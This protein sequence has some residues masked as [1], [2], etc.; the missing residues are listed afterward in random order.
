M[1]MV[2]FW[3]YFQKETYSNGD[4]SVAIFSDA[5]TGKTFKVCGNGVPTAK[6]IKYHLLGE[7]TVYKKTGEESLKLV[8]YEIAELDNE[9]SF[10]EYLAMPPIKLSRVQGKKIY[11][12]FREQAV[13]TLDHEPEKVYNAVFKGLKNGDERYKRFI[14]EWKRQRKLLKISS[15]LVKYG[16]SRKNVMKLNDAVPMSKY[17]DLG[18]VIRDNPYFMM[19]VPGVHIDIGVCDEIA[20]RLHYPLNSPERIKAGMKYVL[21]TAMMNGNMFLYCFGKGGLIEE[22]AKKINVR[23]EEIAAVLNTKPQGFVIESDKTIKNYRI[24]LDYAHEWEVGLAR[25]VHRFLTKRVAKVMDAKGVEKFL[26][27][28]QQKKSITLAEKQKEAVYAVA[29]SPITIITGGAG[30]GKTTSLKAVLAMLDAAGKDNN[31]LL[32]STGKASQRMTETTGRMATTIHSCIACDDSSEDGAAF[33]KDIECDAL[34]IDEFSMT[35]CKVAYL[36]FSAVKSCKR[37]IIVGDVEQLPSVGAGNVLKDMINSGRVRVVALDVIQR[38]AL[39]SPI[40]ANAQKVLC[41]ESDFVFNENFRFI[42]TKDGEEAAEYIVKRYIELVK[43]HGMGAV[44]I[45][46]PMKKRVCGTVM[47]NEAIQNQLFPSLKN[48]K[49][50]IGDKV[51]NTKNNHDIGL[52]NGDMG[53]VTSIVDEEY[54]I[55]F[56][57][58]L[59]LTFDKMEMDH[60]VLAYSVTVHK[61]QGS[62]FPYVIMPI[63]NEHSIMLYRNLL[64]TGITRAKVNIE[65]VGTE[66]MLKKAAETVKIVQ[67]NTML[68]KRL[69]FA[70]AVFDKKKVS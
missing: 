47:L 18:A 55:E 58:G 51:M 21:R 15:F 16:I 13:E 32:A 67:R 56:D 28:Y 69:Q 42:K 65:L 12:L 17:D 31:C 41:G 57:T 24:Y 60:I 20:K 66:E 19:N 30:T 26:R 45:L 46:T 3:G 36:L 27:E 52:S 40:V 29:E 48:E 68:D 4:Y 2:E 61:S 54:T 37:I 49:F 14:Q 43:E 1:N 59:T 10:V 33:G 70:A 53:Y 64:Y 8:D 23:E 35:D 6:K 7:I 5:I 11:K 9:T 44:Q 38:Q 62:E 22:V 25:K 34:V 63:L 39:D 50:R